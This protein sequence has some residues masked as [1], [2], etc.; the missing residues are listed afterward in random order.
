MLETYQTF[1]KHDSVTAVF[2]EIIRFKKFFCRKYKRL[3]PIYT[4]KQKYKTGIK[5]ENKSSD[6]NI[7][8]INNE[9]KT[10]V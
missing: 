5:Q 7:K 6:K 9:K 1:R 4:S 2:Q 3:L 8:K 10:E